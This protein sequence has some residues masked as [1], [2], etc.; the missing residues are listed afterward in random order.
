MAHHKSLELQRLLGRDNLVLSIITFYQEN[1]T[2][3]RFFHYVYTS[4]T[5]SLIVNFR[6][7]HHKFNLSYKIVIIRQSFYNSTQSPT[8]SLQIVILY[9][10]NIIDFFKWFTFTASSYSEALSICAA[11]LYILPIYIWHYLSPRHPN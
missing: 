1:K 9:N 7:C 11:Y 2:V 10:N 4:C 5:F 8:I 6:I 3:D